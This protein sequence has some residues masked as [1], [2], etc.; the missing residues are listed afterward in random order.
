MPIHP[1]KKWLT[2]QELGEYIQMSSSTLYKWA[3]SGRVPGVKVGSQW[4]F[5]VTVIDEWM[6]QHMTGK[7]PGWR[8]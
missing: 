5:E 6:E 1:I 8:S 7:D 4:R 3:Q 2:L